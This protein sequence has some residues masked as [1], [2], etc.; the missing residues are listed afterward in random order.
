MVRAAPGFR[1]PWRGLPAGPGRLLVFG[2]FVNSVGS[3]LWLPANLLYFTQEVGLPAAQV[4]LSMSTAGVIGLFGSSVIGRAIR[5]CGARRTLIVLS[6][7]QTMVV[8]SYSFVTT[9][10]LYLPLVI[11]A[12][13]AGRSGQVCRNVLAAVAASG[14]ETARLQAFTRSANNG[15]F[16]IGVATS[17][18][19]MHL[20]A[21]SPFLVLIAGNALS[22]VATAL[23]AARLPRRFDQELASGKSKGRRSS[24]LRD[25]PFVTVTALTLVLCMRDALLFVGLPLWVTQHTAAPRSLVAVLILVNTVMCVL[26]QVRASRGTGDL[27]GGARALR[28]SGFALAA[29]CLAY[30]AGAAGGAAAASVLLLCGVVVHTLGELWQAA[31]AWGVSFSLSPKEQ[32]PDYQAFFSLTNVGRDVLGPVVVTAVVAWEGGWGV[33]AL[34][35]CGCALACPLAVR[36]AES[37]QLARSQEA[38]LAKAAP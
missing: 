26:F 12:I 18:L 38:G 6:V 34:A 17:G 21:M 20:S 35:F 5:R 16:S 28:R 32:L 4:A 37:T 15:G 11:L 3:G 19:L 2:S 9:F 29:G 33:L 27:R 8:A 22:Y 10:A 23:A 31:G 30:W 24:V 7:L 14:E 13:F 36:W 25:L 1:H